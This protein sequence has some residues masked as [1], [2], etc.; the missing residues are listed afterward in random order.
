MITVT[1]KYNHH[2][3]QPSQLLPLRLPAASVLDTI[4]LSL[5]NISLFRKTFSKF[6]ICYKTFTS[7]GTRAFFFLLSYYEEKKQ[8]QTSTSGFHTDQMN[9]EPYPQFSLL[10]TI[11]ICTNQHIST[12]PHAHSETII[13]KFK[14]ADA[15]IFMIESHARI[16][17][18]PKITISQVFFG[19]SLCH[20]YKYHL[21][22][23]LSLDQNNRRGTVEAP[24]QIAR[25]KS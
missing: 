9:I 11:R 6:V 18:H 17:I 20:D 4:P 12:L 21:A 25:R 3:R 15:T 14:R 23:E 7:M 19:K 16:N 2:L 10:Q 5:L 22:G 13:F 24:R 1:T 8:Y